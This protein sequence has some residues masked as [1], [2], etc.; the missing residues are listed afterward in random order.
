MRRR[1]F[2]F[3]FFLF[4]PSSIFA[5]Y[6]PG[7]ETT[8]RRRDSGVGTQVAVDLF[9][10]LVNQ[11]LQSREEGAQESPAPPSIVTVAEFPADEELKGPCH[12]EV[13]VEQGEEEAVKKKAPLVFDIP[14]Y[15]PPSAAEKHLCCELRSLELANAWHH[16]LAVSVENGSKKTILDPG[17][18]TKLKDDD[19]GECVRVNAVSVRELARPGEPL[20]TEDAR[21]CCHDLRT[22]KSLALKAMRLVN[23][24]LEEKEPPC[25]D[26]ECPAG[27]NPCGVPTE[28]PEGAT[29]ECV[30]RETCSEP[31][32]RCASTSVPPQYSC[33]E[34]Y[35]S[36]SLVPAECP[37]KTKKEC[38]QA[39]TCP[40]E[41]CRC[42]AEE[43]KES[44]PEDYQPCGT[45]VECPEGKRPECIQT[46]T[47][48]E[49]C[50]QCVEDIVKQWCP[51]D[52]QSC[53]SSIECPENT[54]KE[55]IQAETCK[56]PCCRCVPE[57]KKEEEECPE[58]Y[59]ICGTPTEC[60]EKTKKECVQVD[61]CKKPCCKCVSED[62][63]KWCPD[64]Y[65]PCGTP[66]ECPE[67]FKP[68]CVQ[69]PTCPKGCCKCV[70][71]EK[72]YCPPGYPPC[73]TPPEC[74]ENFTLQ[75]VKFPMCPKECCKCIPKDKRS[76]PPGFG[77][78]SPD[79]IQ[80][81]QDH[82][83]ECVQSPDCPYD[84]CR[85]LPPP[86]PPPC[87]C[88]CTLSQKWEVGPAI[89]V[90]LIS[91]LPDPDRVEV[92]VGRRIPLVA[93]AIDRD[94]HEIICHREEAGGPQ[95]AP[96]CDS[97][98]KHYVPITMKYK[99]E[100]LSGV[101]KLI[102]TEGP[103]VL[104]EAP[105]FLPASTR[106]R[107]R[108]T[109]DEDPAHR[110]NV[111]DDPIR[112]DLDLILVDRDQPLKFRVGPGLESQAPEEKR[113]GDCP[114]QPEKK[115]DKNGPIEA[116]DG[117]QTIFACPK[118]FEVVFAQGSDTDL[119]QMQCKDDK[120][121][122][123]E[124]SL[125]QNDFVY[126]QW[127]ATNGRI[128]G[129]PTKQVVM[130]TPEEAPE[131]LITRSITDSGEQA[132]DPPADLPPQRVQLLK[133]KLKE[134][135][136]L[137]KS[138]PGDFSSEEDPHQDGRIFI[139]TRDN[140]EISTARDV[141]RL[142][143]T[144]EIK[145]SEADPGELKVRWE[146]YDPDDPA[147]HRSIDSSLRGGDN[148]GRPHEG[149]PHWFMQADHAISDQSDRDPA[150]A[151]DE[152]TVFGSAK[153]EVS[154]GEGRLLS[155]VYFHYGDDAGDNYRIRAVLEKGGHAQ[156]H[157]DQTGT[158]TV[159]RKRFL[160]VYAMQKENDDEIVHP[161]GARV[162]FGGPCITAGLN[163]F[164]DTLELGGD[165]IRAGHDIFPGV[166][167]ICETVA[168]S[169]DNHFNPEATQDLFRGVYAQ[170]DAN[171]LPY[172]DF[173]VTQEQFDRPIL[174]PLN[175]EAI[176]PYIH[177]R[178][179]FTTHEP[180]IFALLGADTLTE[181]GE[182]YWGAAD[183]PPHAVVAVGSV[184]RDAP[185]ALPKV[186]VHEVGHML[187][188]PDRPG[189]RFHND[190]STDAAHCAYMQGD[191]PEE[192]CPLHASMLRD[193]V[194][195]TF[196]HNHAGGMETNDSEPSRP[197]SP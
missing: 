60:P 90:Q 136:G 15:I 77:P 78:C 96:P 134:I 184:R 114:C 149:A 51:K 110:E 75:C 193:S 26:Q 87:Q 115:W 88:S 192:I 95:C 21:F 82:I 186:D 42:A 127:N 155:T 22:G 125:N 121:P 11:A 162:P 164:S 53:G 189:N 9:S 48:K 80:C 158:L 165:D 49:P 161:P 93:E 179:S 147:D 197:L 85:C 143:L 6:D 132:A 139:D 171:H 105:P 52:Y 4:A 128:I 141:Q 140:R 133:I 170:A 112:Q 175:V 55:C 29:R 130:E 13:E 177:G 151:G 138:A 167:G 61:T 169:G 103:A 50:C 74:P 56:E 135:L 137:R 67:N 107:I 39:P 5:T 35:G 122:S 160:K 99:W 16:P 101:G 69:V 188:D 73:G 81:P 117:E 92:P 45:P 118:D 65:Q 98:L 54:R 111:D 154:R 33:P 116:T 168:N 113:E 150:L 19:W 20:V 187:L 142:K 131:I 79:P 57:E 43:E 153:T 63:K 37:A 58:G 31:C 194:K 10:A 62:E 144:A 109:V 17:K 100:I 123:P 94:Q 25:E 104:Y 76:C 44:C 97:K 196:T 108:L 66:V 146:L 27:F 129:G 91:P 159:W 190:H 24:T 72:N 28:C 172:L 106:V 64:E 46:E 145:P 174:S 191:H 18:T 84:C 89:E 176:P 14:I 38:V 180:N 156:C 152:N 163:S 119:L 2:F 124:E 36:C 12:A 181:F 3:I 40:K 166:N 83:K 8:E 126:Y 1:A 34:G 7:G 183:F 86:P 30:H 185:G 195:R 173:V 157:E 70:P 47:C 148:T 182:H 23:F 178:T 41:C 71:E 102:P 68:Q 32:C 120:C 59:G